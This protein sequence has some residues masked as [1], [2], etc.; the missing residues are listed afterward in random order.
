VYL[1]S[2]M[3]V[4]DTV[5]TC[6]ALIVP[7]VIGGAMDRAAFDIYIETQLAP[8]LVPGT[9]LILNRVGDTCC[10]CCTDRA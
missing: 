4:S 1:S 6:E 3:R 5:L 10:Q 2:L 9:V 7:W 8:A